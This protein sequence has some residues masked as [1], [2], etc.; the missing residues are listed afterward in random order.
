MAPEPELMAGSDIKA[1]QH[2]MDHRLAAWGIG[3]RVAEDGVYGIDT[4]HAAHQV[5][6]GSGLRR[7][8]TPRA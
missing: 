3:E 2:L 7:P 5:A 1:F 8:S 6:L 4:R